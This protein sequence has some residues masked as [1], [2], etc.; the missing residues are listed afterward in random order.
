MCNTSRKRARFLLLRI[1][2]NVSTL[3]F[4]PSAAPSQPFAFFFSLRHQM[5]LTALTLM[6]SRFPPLLASHCNSRLFLSLLP[7]PH[8]LP[9][10]PSSSKKTRYTAALFA[11]ARRNHG[12]FI[13]AVLLSLLWRS[14]R[15]FVARWYHGTKLPRK[16]RAFQTRRLHLRYMYTQ[17]GIE[18]RVNIKLF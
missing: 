8:P 10:D 15:S 5:L 1:R 6:R 4:G 18:C 2:R 13:F 16:N 14:W 7:T 3:L 17:G 9:V 11:R 12:F